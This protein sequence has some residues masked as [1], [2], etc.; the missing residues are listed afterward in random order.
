MQILLGG[1]QALV[2]Y[3]TITRIISLIIAFFLSGAIS[4]FMSQGAVTKYF[5]PNAKRSISY[6]IASVSGAIL[7]VCSCSVLPMFASIRKKGAGIGPAITF[8]FSGPAINVLAIIFTFTLISVDIGFVRVIS[9]IILSVVIGF[10][11]FLLYNKGEIVEANEAMF[12]IGDDN[13]RKGWQ[14]ILFFITL[15]AILISGVKNPV[16]TGVLAIGLIVELLLFFKKDELI[17]WCKAT[18]D[19]A[20]K[21][22]PLFIIGV[23]LAGVIEAVIPPEYMVKYVGNNSFGANLLASVFGAFMYFAT[24]T[25][26]PIVNSFMALGMLK[27]PATALLL[28]GPSLSLPNMI[29]IAKVMGVK[30]AFTYFGLV[31]ILSAIIG[32]LAGYIIYV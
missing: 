1:W 18:Y 21:I 5:G 4:Q 11:M 32:M 31:I 22:I 12:N 3:F 14:N 16:P 7:A 2:G 23:F 10:I 29:V 28:A 6:I 13:S 9:A 19:L 8:L 24:L 20:R 26:V 27:G 30:K 15:I 17:E 25:E